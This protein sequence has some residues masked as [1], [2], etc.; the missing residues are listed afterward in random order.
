MLSAESK[1]W[2]LQVSIPLS[3]W[4]WLDESSVTSEYFC[5]NHSGILK[6]KF[7]FR[8]E[9]TLAWHLRLQD[10]CRNFASINFN[11]SCCILKVFMLSIKCVIEI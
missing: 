3:A 5:K 10:A 6:F 7:S 9:K 1:G 8:K 2:F 4:T 11:A